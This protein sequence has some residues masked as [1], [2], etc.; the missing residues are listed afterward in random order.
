MAEVDQSPQGTVEQPL[1]M[2]ARC[3]NC[4]YLLDGLPHRVCP[5]CGQVFDPACRGTYFRP[6][7]PAWHKSLCRWAAPPGLWHAVVS[8]AVLAWLNE[9]LWG[10][11][12]QGAE[13]DHQDNSAR[14]SNEQ[15]CA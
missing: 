7:Q 15:A 12:I 6:G 3:L 13:R 10:E 4:R 14:P 1:P 8:V 11:I 9:T 2:G 5:E